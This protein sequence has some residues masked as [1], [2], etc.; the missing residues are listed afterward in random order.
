MLNPNL[1]IQQTLKNN[2]QMQQAMEYIKANGGDAKKAFYK[3][4]EENGID[5]QSILDN[6]AKL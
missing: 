6:F 5:P 3:L 1:M 2:P 4:A